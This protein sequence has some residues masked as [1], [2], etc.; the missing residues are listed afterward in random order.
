M[1]PPTAL[2]RMSTSRRNFMASTPQ[3]DAH[4]QAHHS[5]GPV[6]DQRQAQRQPLEEAEQ[7]HAHPVDEE[8]RQAAEHAHNHAD[9]GAGPHV[10]QKIQGG[11][12]ADH[13]AQQK[14]GDGSPDLDELI[15]EKAVEQGKHDAERQQHLPGACHHS[16]Q[17]ADGGIRSEQHGKILHK[18]SIFAK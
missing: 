7:E 1:P 17:G 16:L 18:P 10:L 11:K 14:A 8:R 6:G 5:P 12:K 9:E 3:G 2:E 15:A 13:P 4:D